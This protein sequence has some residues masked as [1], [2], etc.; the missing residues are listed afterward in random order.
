MMSDA[1]PISSTPFCIVSRL[2]IWAKRCGSQ[3]SVAML[4]IT[5]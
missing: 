5:R 2:E 3:E 1:P 4:L